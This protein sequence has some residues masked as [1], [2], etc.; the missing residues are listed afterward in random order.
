MPLRAAQSGERLLEI[1]ATT[2]QP[3]TPVIS[4]SRYLKATRSSRFPK[5]CCVVQGAKGL[6]GQVEDALDNKVGPAARRAVTSTT[7]RSVE[8]TQPQSQPD[9]L[10]GTAFALFV[11]LLLVID[12]IVLKLLRLSFSI[13]DVCACMLARGCVVCTSAARSQYYGCNKQDITGTW[14][15]RD[16]GILQPYPR[17]SQLSPCH[18][19][20]LQDRLSACCCQSLDHIQCLTS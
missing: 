18:V 9:S 7:Q 5:P 20:S 15:C 4:L 14:C 3:V 1:Q 19:S 12:Y 8:E 13:Y 11:V 16:Y 6:K 17:A 10:G 2:N